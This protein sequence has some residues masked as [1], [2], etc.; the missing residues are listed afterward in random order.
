MSQKSDKQK[1]LKILAVDDEEI[2]RDLYENIF[3]ADL[4]K[5]PLYTE[6]DEFVYSFFDQ[7]EKGFE[8]LQSFGLDT[9]SQ[10]EEAVRLVKVALE[11]D[12]PYFVVFL[13]VRMPPGRDGVWAAQQIRALDPRINIVIVTAYSDFHPSEITARLGSYRHFLYIQK[14]FCLEEIYQLAISLS[15][16]WLMQHQLTSIK[17]ELEKR[18]VEKTADLLQT[19]KRLQDEICE[20][21]ELAEQLRTK[22]KKLENMNTTLN[23]LLEKREQDRV[24]ADEKILQNLTLQVKPFVERLQNS[25]LSETQT[26]YLDMIKKGHAEITSSFSQQLTSTSLNLTPSEVQVANFIK[27][28]KSTKE[29]ANILNLSVR[30]IETHRKNIRNKMGLKQK[31]QSLRSSLL[32]FK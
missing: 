24:D 29:I 17:E 14:P 15:E 13:D 26:R 1:L 5:T 31:K 23:M 3:S 7:K 32:E 21:V 2:I 18:V 12:Q 9:C 22:S 10:A 4:L 27:S 16:N 6:F 11:N 19:N 20:R 30:T 8:N 28:G 25:G